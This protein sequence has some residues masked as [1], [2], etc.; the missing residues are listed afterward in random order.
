MFI[1]SPLEQFEV[2]SLISL[3]IPLFGYINFSLTNL[4]LYA[5]ITVYLVI[6]LHIF[7]SNNFILIA[8]R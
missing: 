1:Y 3:N 6:S 8:N 7:G 5:L 4:G 2:I